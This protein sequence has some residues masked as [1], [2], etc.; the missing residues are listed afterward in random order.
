MLTAYPKSELLDDQTDTRTFSA[1][2]LDM[3]VRTAAETAI[4][5]VLSVRLDNRK[6]EFD[7]GLVDNSSLS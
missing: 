5:D 7:S 2:K 6:C 3:H 4:S 1:P